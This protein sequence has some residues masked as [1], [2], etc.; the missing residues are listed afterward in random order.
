MADTP[1][2]SAN[3]VRP[4]DADWTPTEPGVRRRILTW[5]DQLMLVEVA[6]EQGAVGALHRHPHI[7][8]S[9]VAAGSF[10]VTI[11]GVTETLT[12]GQS[13]IAP[14]NE[15]HGVRALEPGTLIDAFTPMRA[16]FL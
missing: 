11:S 12:R 7:Q 15:W 13:F 3:V 16:E 2:A 4:A 1:T 10:E 14:S 6:F 8:A 5:N 9:Y